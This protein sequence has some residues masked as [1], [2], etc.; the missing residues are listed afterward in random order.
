MEKKGRENLYFPFLFLGL[1]KQYILR[2]NSVDNNQITFFL[3]N[4]ICKTYS[5][6]SK[7]LAYVIHTYHLVYALVSARLP[8]GSR[9]PEIGKT[10]GST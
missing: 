8:P 9:G 3:I 2:E 6:M 7:V 10:Q 5:I 4:A 1:T